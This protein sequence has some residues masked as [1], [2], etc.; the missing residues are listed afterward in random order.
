MCGEL[1]LRNDQP[2]SVIH[3]E[4]KNKAIQDLQ[5]EYE[6]F[7][8]IKAIPLTRRREGE[9]TSSIK[10]FKRQDGNATSTLEFGHYDYHHHGFRQ[11]ETSSGIIQPNGSYQEPERCGFCPSDLPCLCGKDGEAS[12]P[13]FQAGS[14]VQCQNDPM[15]TLFCTTLF[16]S[17]QPLSPHNIGMTI[18]CFEAYQTISRH[19]NF[20]M[21]D[22]GFIVS[23]LETDGDRVSVQSITKAL[24]IMN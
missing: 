11:G 1:G 16:A 2:N 10:K 9:P 15:G 21:T 23:H 20:G 6:N 18:S 17:A 19:Q 5:K 4:Q 24:M 13:V 14:C 7:V 22:L 3:D 12:S 8:P